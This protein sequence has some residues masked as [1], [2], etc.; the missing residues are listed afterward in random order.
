MHTCWNLS[1]KHKHELKGQFLNSHYSQSYIYQY[2][3]CFDKLELPQNVVCHLNRMISMY[4]VNWLVFHIQK[5]AATCLGDITTAQK[6]SITQYVLCL[7]LFHSS[8]L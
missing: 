4:S 1:S 7:K 6:F 3:V 5:E 2:S 8:N